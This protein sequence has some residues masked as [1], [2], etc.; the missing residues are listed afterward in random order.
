MCNRND[1]LIICFRLQ[2]NRQQAANQPG[3]LYIYIYILVHRYWLVHGS[4]ERI[5]KNNK[6]PKRNKGNKMATDIPRPSVSRLLE[7][8][9]GGV[10]RDPARVN[11]DAATL[12]QSSIGSHLRPIATMYA[13]ERTGDTNTVLDLQGTVAIHYRGQTYQLL[14]D[15]YIIGQY[16]IQPPVCYVRLVPHMY[17]KENHRHV[18]SDT[19]RVFIPYLS[20]WNSTTHNLIELIVAISSIFSNDPP[21]FSRPPPPP[22]PSQQQPQQ[23]PPPP[24]PPPLQATLNPY[25]PNTS[26]VPITSGT[27][28]NSAPSSGNSNWRRQQEQLEAALFREAQ[29]ANQA[30]EAVRKSE[31]EE[32]ER[33]KAMQ[34]YEATQIQHLK[35]TLNAKIQTFC[36]EQRTN[37]QQHVMDDYSDS[38]ALNDGTAIQRQ[39]QEYQT[40]QNTLQHHLTVVDQATN[41]IQSWLQQ[42]QPQ[43]PLQHSEP[44]KSIDEI[45]TTA[46]TIQDRM[47][48][49][50]AENQTISDTLYFLDKA[51]YEQTISMDVHLKHVRTLAKQQFYARAHFMKL[52]QEQQQLLLL[53]P[54]PK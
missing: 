29:E 39:I 10:Y 26:A 16:P 43:P 40:L 25:H 41:E 20:E 19:G 51:L 17:I 28:Y 18:Q 32:T 45:V 42:Q 47:I 53:S 33:Q 35:N 24:P 2:H 31:Q 6:H 46:N 36:R 23:P 52:Q 15:I 37:I 54:P 34:V 30:V 50:E 5:N 4:I 14:M 38:A 44:K 1:T 12:L 7:Q 21:V 48:E 49:Y 13:D 27:T 22:P 11:R 3:T 8:R 9:L